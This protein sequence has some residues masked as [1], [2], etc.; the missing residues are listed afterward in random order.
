MASSYQ[1]SEEKVE[2]SDMF[3]GFD[4]A[5]EEEGAWSLLIYFNF[6]KSSQ[7]IHFILQR[8]RFKQWRQKKYSYKLRIV[9]KILVKTRKILI[10]YIE[11]RNCDII[12][13]Y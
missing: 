1:E 10:L 8:H 9:W 7:V 4:F 5:G 2:K 13:K 6:Y 11:L 3:E 12:K